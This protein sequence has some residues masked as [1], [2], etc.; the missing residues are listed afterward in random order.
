MGRA[1]IIRAQTVFDFGQRRGILMIRAL[2]SLLVLCTSSSAAG[3]GK[4]SA[5]E[6]TVLPIQRISHEQVGSTS[7]FFDRCGDEPVIITGLNLTAVQW[8]FEELVDICPAHA[9][10]PVMEATDEKGRWARIKMQGMQKLSTFMRAMVSSNPPN[11]YGFDFNIQDECPALLQRFTAPSFASGDL[12]GD[13]KYHD[14]R[15]MYSWPSLMSGPAGTGS[16]LHTDNDG[17]PFWMALHRGRK[18][19][20]VMSYGM[21]FHLTTDKRDANNNGDPLPTVEGKPYH[22]AVL[23]QYLSDGSNGYLYKAFDPDFEKFPDLA[24]AVVHEGELAAGEVIFMPNS[25]PHGARNLEPTIATTANFFV[26]EDKRQWAWLQNTCERHRGLVAE[27]VVG[28]DG[29]EKRFVQCHKLLLGET[30]NLKDVTP[31]RATDD[32]QVWTKV[33]NSMKDPLE[34]YWEPGGEGEPVHVDTLQPGGLVKQGTYVGHEFS[35][36]SGGSHGRFQIQQGTSEYILG[37]EEPQAG[38]DL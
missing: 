4:A 10:I 13:L 3:T 5:A 28:N 16:E 32:E 34:L 11:L 17:L 18:H 26:K 9:R 22:S 36:R 8:T 7:E 31:S 1:S 38:D 27:N 35:W 29:H 6:W 25:A 2:V 37:S 20:R 30:V 14:G 19:Y 21:N 23:A 33:I 15:H 12:M 24:Q